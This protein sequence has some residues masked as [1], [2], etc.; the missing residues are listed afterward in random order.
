GIAL[1]FL[2][3]LLAWVPFRATS[4]D[5]ALGIYAGMAGGNGV[6]GPG[7]AAEMIFGVAYG[8]ARYQGIDETCALA[9][10]ALL[11]FLAP[12]TQQFMA[13]F[14]PGLPSRVA[15]PR[16]ERLHLEWQ[17][18]PAWSFAMTLV[19]LLALSRMSGVS[20]FLYYQF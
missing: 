18:L 1:T 11:T 19:L 17:P 15:E 20:P 7:G 9:A 5:A 6:A 16:T 13:R 4:F 10:L 3:V 12:N 14:R 2:A 8:A